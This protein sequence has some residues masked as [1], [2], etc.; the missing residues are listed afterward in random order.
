VI[1][2]IGSASIVSSNMKQGIGKQQHQ[3]VLPLV[4]AR[5][6]TAPRLHAI[7]VSEYTQSS[8]QL[9]AGMFV[10]CLFTYVL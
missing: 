4:A 2:S 10:A 9:G 1:L 8:L 6:V 7:M 5:S 3:P